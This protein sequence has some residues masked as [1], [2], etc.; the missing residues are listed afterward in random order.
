M[1]VV[2]ILTID[3][4]Y[5]GSRQCL[6]TG[7]KVVREVLSV[8]RVSKLG[9]SLGAHVVVYKSGKVK[10]FKVR[11]PKHVDCSLPS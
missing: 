9:T 4:T 5:I 1:A 11:G 6:Q 3:Y 10:P 8:V 7:Y 2:R